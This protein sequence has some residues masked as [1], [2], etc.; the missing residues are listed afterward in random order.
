VHV[1]GASLLVD[2]T[3]F[4]VCPWWD[5]PVGRESLQARLAADA[6]R[7]KRRWVWIYHAPPTAS[8]LSWDGRREFGDEALTEWL[9]VFRPDVVLTGHIHQAPFVEG[10]DWIQ[11]IGA[12]WLFNAGQQ[13]GPVPAYIVLDLE[14]GLAEW[15]SATERRAAA[16]LLS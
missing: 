12:T 11:Q 15:R 2:E 8:P 13:P 6:G 16:V 7:A 14:A 10:G 9:P 4:T 1:D 5:G 3:L